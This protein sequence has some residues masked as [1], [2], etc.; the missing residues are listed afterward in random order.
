MFSYEIDAL[1]KN[2]EYII[3]MDDYKEIIA[4]SQIIYIKFDPWDDSFVINTEDRY[5][6]KFRVVNTD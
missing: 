3:T 6:W 4:S 1:L 2:K 5:S